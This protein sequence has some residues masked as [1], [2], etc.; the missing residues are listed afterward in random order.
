MSSQKIVIRLVA[1]MTVT[2]MLAGCSFSLGNPT[3][4]P[5]ATET[6]MP[7][8]G[9]TLDLQAT[10]AAIGT[11]AAQTVIAGL[12]QSAPSAT[13]VPTTPVPATAEPTTDQ[14]ATIQAV[15]TQA[16]Q[17]V[18]AGLT[19]N[20]PTKTPIPPTA[21]STPTLSPTP[22]FTKTPKT[23]TTTPTLT[24]IPW[25]TT[26]SLT[27]TLTTY[28]CTITSVSPA[29]TDTLKTGVDFDGKWVVK[30]TG[31]Q[32]WIHTDVDIKYLSGTKFQVAGEDLLDTK[33]DV[34][35]GASYTVIVDMVAP[36]N[37]GTY[38]ASWALVR[39]SQ[40]ICNMYLTLVVVK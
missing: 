36:A 12:T 33:S 35:S 21:T 22:T 31:T 38:Y 27:A 13:L 11:Q 40:V 3:L 39:S 1:V 10:G 8:A 9:P 5:A 6:V 23:P 15:K 26:P 32:P 28:N 37:A 34:P 2:I 17:T 7:T 30:N 14:Q 20:A 18:I 19:Q 25:T 24:P 16:A 29:A 4:G